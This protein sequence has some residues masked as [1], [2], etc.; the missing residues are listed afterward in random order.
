MGSVSIPGRIHT[1]QADFGAVQNLP[2]ESFNLCEI[3]TGKSISIPQYKI[4][5]HILLLL[6]SQSSY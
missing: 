4:L 5:L 6:H 3:T 1:H 2:L